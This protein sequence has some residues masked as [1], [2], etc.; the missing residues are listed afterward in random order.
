[1]DSNPGRLAGVCM[2]RESDS[3]QL[4]KDLDAPAKVTLI[5]LLPW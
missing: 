1:M 3:L 4:R 5:Q 2:D